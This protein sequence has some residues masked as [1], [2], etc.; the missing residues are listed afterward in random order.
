MKSQF[1]TGKLFEFACPSC[2]RTSRVVHPELLYHDPEGG[3]LV[4]LDALGKFDASS[5][6]DFESSLPP[7]TRVVR[8]SNALLEKIH[9]FDAGLD[10]RVLEVLKIVVAVQKQI[11]GADRVETLHASAPTDEQHIQRWLSANC[12]G[13]HLTR[14]GLDVP[15]RELLTFAMLAQSPVE[16]PA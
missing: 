9:I 6:R 12:F 13:D 5:L 7:V 15:T 11:V 14:A 16:Q 10:D 1:L 8:D 2:G 4:Q 3:L